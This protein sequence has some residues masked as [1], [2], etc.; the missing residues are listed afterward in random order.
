MYYEDF[1]RA[2]RPN[3]GR[4]AESLIPKGDPDSDS[5]DSCSLSRIPIDVI[6]DIW[7]EGPQSSRDARNNALIRDGYRCVV[8]G[9]YEVDA[10]DRIKALSSRIMS[11]DPT[12]S[13]D[14]T[15]CTY[16]FVPP[17]DTPIEP[18]SEK[19][20]N[21]GA[22]WAILDHFGYSEI[23]GELNG[24]KIHRFENIMT[25]SAL[26]DELFDNLQLWF[27]KTDEED[28]Y[29]LEATKFHTFLIYREL[30]S[31]G[32]VTFKSPD[33]ENLPVPSSIYLGIHAACAKVAYF[34]GASE[35]IDKIARQHDVEE[36]DAATFTDSN[37]RL[38]ERVL[39][40]GITELRVAD[41]HYIFK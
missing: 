18:G 32:Y 19:R 8:S 14:A 26:A 41:C 38:A 12:F 1:I 5:D 31:S 10:I 4:D 25:M 9:R 22:L 3:K 16:V 2:F 33:P 34:S 21:A 20:D 35:Y 37:G 15:K 36:I 27:V 7:T 24:S 30:A 23:P 17:T 11:D 39:D 13:I 40:R 6:H 28:K 29:K